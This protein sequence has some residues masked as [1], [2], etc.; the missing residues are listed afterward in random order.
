MGIVQHAM[1]DGILSPRCKECES[2]SRTSDSSQF[3]ASSAPSH[4]YPGYQSRSRRA[5]SFRSAFSEGSTLVDIVDSSSFSR[6][7]PRTGR[8]ASSRISYDTTARPSSKPVRSSIY[9]SDTATPELPPSVLLPNPDKEKLPRRFKSALRSKIESLKM[10]RSMRRKTSPSTADRA[11]RLSERRKHIRLLRLEPSV[12]VNGPI[13][14]KLERISLLGYQYPS[15]DALSYRW[16]DADPLVKIIIDGVQTPVSP[17]VM[18]ILL[19]LRKPDGPCLLWI[20]SLCIRQQDTIEKEKQIRLMPDIYRKSNRVVVWLGDNA[21]ESPA[22][23]SMSLEAITSINRDI[24]RE[25]SAE[26]SMQDKLFK[27]DGTRQMSDTSNEELRI[28][29]ELALPYFNTQWFSR[30]WVVQEVALAPKGIC[31]R[32]GFQTD[33][34]DVLRAAAWFVYKLGNEDV[35]EHRNIRHAATIFRYADPDFAYYHNK[36]HTL[37][38]WDQYLKRTP[39]QA[40]F[41]HPTL[42]VLLTDLRDQNATEPRD[43]TYGLLSLTEW[44]SKGK[45]IPDSLQPNY[46][47]PVAEVYREATREAIRSAGNLNVLECVSRHDALHATHYMRGYD[48]DELPCWCPQWDRPF[49]HDRDASG[50]GA[51]FRADGGRPMQMMKNDST[52]FPSAIRLQGLELDEV[53]ITSTVMRSGVLCCQPGLLPQAQGHFWPTVVSEEN[54][55]RRYLK[56]DEGESSLAVALLQTLGAGADLNDT[57]Q[58]ESL[59]A[60]D[61]D[62]LSW[63]RDQHEVFCRMNKPAIEKAC[64]NRRFFVTKSGYMGTG[65]KTMRTGNKLVLLYGGKW[66]F[67]LY[68]TTGDYYYF[69]GPCYAHG[70]MH[71]EVLKEHESE[72]NK[73]RVFE[74]R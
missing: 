59:L 60:P 27:V 49:S 53:V 22:D 10:K 43:K 5:S 67:L 31:Y 57:A 51:H 52:A 19:A 47:K 71:G 44:T 56:Q 14:C 63:P 20:D 23:I 29:Y 46:N 32:R 8:P 13:V 11:L 33:L 72:T 16:Q 30:R 24:R 9:S 4:L 68:P 69:V 6:A 41:R 18:D 48:R 26:E 54:V 64:R 73:S 12:K 66:P 34:T 45:K 36:K 7:V 3:Y 37:T 21:D 62:E 50:L 74:V 28:R 42:S 2:A 39:G 35:P 1:Y 25:T 17:T 65:P 15:Y 38:P 58:D 40:R 55:R 61:S 70:I